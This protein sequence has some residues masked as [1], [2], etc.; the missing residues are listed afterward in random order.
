MAVNE[1]TSLPLLTPYVSSAVLAKLGRGA[2]DALAPVERVRGAILL[3][4]IAGFTPMV[5]TLSGMG[6][7]GIDALRRLLA[8]YY[9]G[10]IEVVQAWGGDVYQFAGDSILA[11]FETEPGE[12]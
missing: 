12:E 10:M 1:V 5:V 9:T 7:R 6:P 8:S 2:K 4:D 3:L 11:L